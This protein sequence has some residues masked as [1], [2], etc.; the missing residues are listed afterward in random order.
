MTITKARSKGRAVPS[1]GMP[2]TGS[3]TVPAEYDRPVSDKR[4]MCE[5][6]LGSLRNALWNLH[7]ALQVA[8]TVSTGTAED[9]QEVTTLAT[10]KAKTEAKIVLYEKL[11]AS[12]PEDEDGDEEVGDDELDLPVEP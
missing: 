4:V 11:L 3:I 5:S 9:K 7:V 8:K 2:I 10:R 1:N 12:L 6:E